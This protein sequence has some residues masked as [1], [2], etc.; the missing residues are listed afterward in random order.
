MAP[1][2]PVLAL[3]GSIASLFLVTRPTGRL[4][5]FVFGGLFA[6]GGTSGLSAEKLAYAVILVIL[7]VI[8][9]ARLGGTL[10]AIEPQRRAAARAMLGASLL[11]FV[12]VVFQALMGLH[13]G[14]SATIV[15][16][17]AFT[18]VLLVVAPLIALDAAVG[19]SLRQLKPVV[20][21]AGVLAASSWAVYWLGRRGSGFEG[22]ERVALPTSFLAFAVFAIALVIG[23]NARRQPERVLWLMFAAAIAV[24]YISS[25][26]RSLL[27]FALGLLGILGAR[28]FGRLPAGLSLVLVPVFL[29]LAAIG[30]GYLVRLLPDGERILE[31]FARTIDLLGGNGSGLASDGS[32]SDR[33]R[34]YESTWQFFTESPLLGNGLGFIYPRVNSA[35]DDGL[36]LDSPILILAKFGLIGIIPLLVFTVAFFRFVSVHRGPGSI[37]LAGTSLRVFGFIALGRL[38]FVAPTEDKGLGLGLALLIVWAVVVVASGPESWRVSAGTSTPVKSK[39]T[40]GAGRTRSSFQTAP[41]TGVARS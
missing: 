12:L 6:L 32:F 25:G 35:A 22:L 30:T 23:V 5:L 14:R 36:S 9:L 34:A 7:V 26:S 3:L 11:Y 38:F 2:I 39:R 20:V 18:Y 27:V 17:D 8:A 13:D 33:T 28:K 4:A 19:M 15:A 21:V 41:R 24:I 31:R 37:R 1:F 16:Q 40:G 10:A 29:F